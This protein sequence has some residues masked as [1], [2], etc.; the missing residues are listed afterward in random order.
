M[1]RRRLNDNT[2]DN[3]DESPSI[4]STAPLE[5]TMMVEV[6]NI[7]TG[8]ECIGKL[9]TIP[10]NASLSSGARLFQYN[11]FFWNKDIFTFNYSNCAC[12]IAVAFRSQNYAESGLPTGTYLL[13]YPIFL[14]RTALC[15][16]QSLMNGVTINPPQRKYLVDDLLYYLNGSFTS[17]NF[18]SIALGQIVTL[19]SAAPFQSGPSLYGALKKGFLARPTSNNYYF[20]LF[21]D[22]NEPP[23]KWI[24]LSSNGQIALVRNKAF[25]DNLPSSGLPS[26]L[27]MAFQIVSPE[28]QFLLGYNSFASSTISGNPDNTICYPTAP[29]LRK[30]QAFSY[31]LPSAFNASAAS[32]GGGFTTNV[33]EYGWCGQGAYATGF[34]QAQSLDFP[35]R[36]S[37][38]YQSRLRRLDLFSQ[39]RFPTY[40]HPL[41]I[42]DFDAWCTT[43]QMSRDIVISHK[44]TSFIPTRFYTIESEI[45]TRDQLMNPVS[46]NPV[47]S[48]SSIIGIEYVDLNTPRTKVDSTVSGKQIRTDGD[49][50][51][52]HMNPFYSIQSLDLKM[53]DEWGNYLQNFRTPGGFTLEFS[54]SNYSLMADNTSNYSGNYIYSMIEAE[55]AFN[56]GRFTIP[57][58]L[59]ALNPNTSGGNTQPLIAPF[60]T[61]MSQSSYGIYATNG[62]P[63]A[64][65]SWRNKIPSDFSPNISISGNMIHFG[66]VLGY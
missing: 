34:G 12:F 58:W 53:K 60:S 38:V 45:L 43:Y 64:V 66:R 19:P 36:Y 39:T 31:S 27:E 56:N 48:S 42:N 52:N 63:A 14:P 9:D 3:A 4:Y 47:L 61:Y 13:F 26:D 23:L 18:D 35:N 46:N 57:A 29:F 10:V 22:V 28:Y 37:D 24:Y 55:N 54:G 21:Q 7:A 20:P 41:L 65:T 1:K 17:Y 62:G 50:P 49:T 44:I 11:R 51:V 33:A 5:S 8:S 30:N 6:G 15:T 32:G 25:W 2:G 40:D 16:F 59:A